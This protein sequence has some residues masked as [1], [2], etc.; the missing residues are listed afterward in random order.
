MVRRL[1]IRLRR[2]VL[3][4]PRCLARVRRVRSLQFARQRRDA[5]RQHYRAFGRRAAHPRARDVRP[6][7]RHPAHHWLCAIHPD[8]QQAAHQ[9]ARQ[10]RRHGFRGT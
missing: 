5:V 4:H 8:R 3:G 9:Q 7:L 2:G 6:C 10:R 1:L